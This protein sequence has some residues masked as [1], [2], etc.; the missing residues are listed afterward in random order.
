MRV[1][2]FVEIPDMK[3]TTQ[4]DKAVKG[5]LVGYFVIDGKVE[6]ARNIK[7]NEPESGH[8]IVCNK[9]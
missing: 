2:F 7:V 6:L 1:M 5:K 9:N 8:M 4:D 3:R